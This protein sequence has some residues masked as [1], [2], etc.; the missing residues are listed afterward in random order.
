MKKSARS[1][2][3]PATPN[4]PDL[5]QGLSPAENGAEL[6]RDREVHLQEIFLEN[7][8]TPDLPTTSLRLDSCV[9][10]TVNLANSKLPSLRLRDVRF[11]SCDLANVDA[12]GL[13]GTRVEFVNCRMTGFRAT[14][15]DLQD[16]RIIEGDQRYLQFR[17][18]IFKSAWFESCNFEEADFE[19]TDLRGARFQDCNLSNAEMSGA[20]LSGADLRGS[21]VENLRLKAAD[22]FGAIV[23]APQAMIFSALLGIKIR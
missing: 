16:V 7:V 5:P 1:S 10:K 12:R 18:G 20:K 6:F 13:T 23:D 17:V 11:D 14:E 19:G 9:L 3:T 2:E 21:R 15:A 8:Q 22:I 4:L